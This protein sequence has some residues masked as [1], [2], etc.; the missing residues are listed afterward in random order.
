MKQLKTHLNKKKLYLSFVTLLGLFFLFSTT[1]C[2]KDN[3]N[4]SAGLSFSTDTLTFDTLFSTIGSTTRFFTIRNT[5]KQALKISNI[6]LSGGYASAYRINV[7]GDSGVA[8]NNII[9]PPKDSLYVFVE[10]TINPTAANLP[11]VVEDSIQFITNGNLQQVQLNTYGQNAH[12]YYADSITSNTIWNNDKPYVIMNYLQIKQGAALTINKNCKVYFGSG[13]AL[14]VEG[15]LNINGQDTANTVTFRGIRLDK[16]IAG[17]S[18]DDFPG[19]Y[20]GLFFLRESTGNINYLNMR[21]SIYGI[22]VGNIKTSDNPAQNTAALQAMS[23]TNA[24]FVSIKNSKIYNHSVYGLYGFLGKIYAEN[25]LV[26]NCGKNVL[27]LYDGGDY[28]FLNCTFYS[29]SSTYIPH[30]KDPL[31]YINNYFN[32]NESAYLYADAATALFENC[33]TYGSL[34]EEIIVDNNNSNPIPVTIKFDH[35]VV[36]T[37][38]PADPSIFINFKIADPLFK[39]IYK[40]D[41]GLKNNSP[42][43]NYSTNTF[44][45]ADIDGFLRTGSVT[46]CGAYL[47]R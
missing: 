43:I 8:F 37:K 36:K 30:T 34:D 23:I 7:D 2:K 46:D 45:T 32:I 44:P 12:F 24:P 15:D 17:R 28:Q 20:A 14:L 39:D 27:G 19:Q 29:G 41:F 10:V 9:I 5:Q 35:C 31:L 22:N 25:T 1:A 26:Y 13:A 11:F 16:D 4:T 18:Y 38:T 6:R 40:N 21:N 33:I 42:C 47:Y 3:L